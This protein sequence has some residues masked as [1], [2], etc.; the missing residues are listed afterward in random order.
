M[1]I[2]YFVQSSP[3]EV[4]SSSIAVSES[5]P[6][7]SVDIT[8]STESDQHPTEEEPVQ[9]DALSQASLPAD[10]PTHPMVT[11]SKVGVIQ[12]NPKY[13]LC[14]SNSRLWNLITISDLYPGHLI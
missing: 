13:R 5:T 14:K 11:R 9:V 1:D 7:V 2:L 3:S 8:S 6:H 12:P 4:L 10:L